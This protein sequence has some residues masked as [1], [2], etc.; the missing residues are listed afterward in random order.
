MMADENPPVTDSTDDD[1][2][3]VAAVLYLASAEL[4]DYGACMSEKNG[5]R[6]GLPSWEW[7]RERLDRLEPARPVW[8]ALSQGRVLLTP[9][10]AAELRRLA[11]EDTSATEGLLM[12]LHEGFGE[13]DPS[14]GMQ[15]LLARV[16]LEA[17][18]R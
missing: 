14:A 12:M 3:A 4:D 5:G 1:R 11:A 10:L 7:M 18:A 17:V 6:W 13:D 2:A 16:D 8:E 9:W 15:L